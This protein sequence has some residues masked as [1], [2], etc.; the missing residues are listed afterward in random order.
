VSEADPAQALGEAELMDRAVALGDGQELLVG[1]V[2]HGSPGGPADE[3]VHEPDVGLAVPQGGQPQGVGVAF[4]CP[5]AAGRRPEAPSDGEPGPVIA[6]EV[7]A[8]ADDEDAGR[9]YLSRT[10]CTEQEMQGS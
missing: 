2:V 5:Q 8:E 7:V 10:T 9:R 3:G 1:E 6:D 4:D